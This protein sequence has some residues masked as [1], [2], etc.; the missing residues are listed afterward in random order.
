MASGRALVMSVVAD[1]SANTAPITDAPVMSPRW[2][3]LVSRRG[4]DEAP[5]DEAVKPFGR[6]R[7]IVTIVGGFATALVLARGS[8]LIASVPERHI[9]SLRAGMHRFRVPVAMQ[10]DH[11][12]LALAPAAECRSGTPLAARLCSGRLPV[13]RWPLQGLERIR[14]KKGPGGNRRAAELGRRKVVA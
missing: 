1:A 6:K 11:G 13:A 4:L 7:E 10:G 12:L 2:H 9:G 3:I 5:I 14:Q 8:D